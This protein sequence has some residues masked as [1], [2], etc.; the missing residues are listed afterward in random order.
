MIAWFSSVSAACDM[1][2]PQTAVSA[3][4]ITAIGRPTSASASIALYSGRS[5][6][7]MPA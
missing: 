3:P 6:R 2:M 5:V 7:R 1:T 4:H